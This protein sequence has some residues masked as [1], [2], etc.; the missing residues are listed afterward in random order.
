MA[1]T[2]IHLSLYSLC[3]SSLCAHLCTEIHLVCLPA[4]CDVKSWPTDSVM[5][6]L[7]NPGWNENYLRNSQNYQCQAPP[8]HSSLVGLW[9]GWTQVLLY[10]LPRG[11]W[12][13]VRDPILATWALGTDFT[14]RIFPIL[15]AFA[16]V[17][18]VWISQETLWFGR[19][20]PGVLAKNNQEGYA[21]CTCN[22]LCF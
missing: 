21:W 11:L 6:E 12:C 17:E 4:F 22:K 2:E 14:C 18:G 19:G 9:S 3:F 16:Q 1:G 5:T 10:K 8:G 13:A 15:Q 20:K 7:L